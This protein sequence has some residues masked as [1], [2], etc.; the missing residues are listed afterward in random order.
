MAAPSTDLMA[1]MAAVGS[2]AL[3]ACWY[4][5]FGAKKRHEGTVIA[6]RATSVATTPINGSTTRRLTEGST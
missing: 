1:F 3:G 4:A 6:V 2:G 5:A